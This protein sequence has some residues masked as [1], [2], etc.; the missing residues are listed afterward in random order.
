MASHKPPLSAEDLLSKLRAGTKE[1]HEITMR[2]ATINV[3]VLS[4]EEVNAIRRE[5]IAK[6]ANGAGD[7]V[8]RNVM[9]QRLT[10]KLASTLTKN[11]APYLGDKLLALMSVDE[12]NYLYEEYMRAMDSVNPSLQTMTAEQFRAIVDALKKNTLSSKDLSLLQLR[13]VCTA[14]VELIQQLESQKSPKAS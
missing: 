6:C 14:F 10:L 4:I 8:D 7:E 9:I 13:T 12:V 1:T 5:S 11:G 3:R 2:D